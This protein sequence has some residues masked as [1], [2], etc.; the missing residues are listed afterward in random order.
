LALTT[1]SKVTFQILHR[2]S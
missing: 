2:S 1:N